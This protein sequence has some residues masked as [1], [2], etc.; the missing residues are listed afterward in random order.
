M[1]KERILKCISYGALAVLIV[2]MMAATVLEKIHGT[3]FALH[4]VYHNPVFIALW[5]VAAVS[6]L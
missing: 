5:G 3:E 6:G 4:W 1:K 2:A